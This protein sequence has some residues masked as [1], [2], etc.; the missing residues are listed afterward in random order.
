[1]LK[2][3]T[4]CLRPRAADLIPKQTDFR[5][6]YFPLHPK[7]GSRRPWQFRNNLNVRL[8]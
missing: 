5:A 3:G 6:F 1:M 2:Y 7:C 4:L 8:Y